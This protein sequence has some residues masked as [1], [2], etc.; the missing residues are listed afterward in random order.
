MRKKVILRFSEVMKENKA[1]CLKLLL[2][3]GGEILLDISY[4]D[5]F[6]EGN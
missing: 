4:S 2:L 5:F 6:S 3:L 1:A